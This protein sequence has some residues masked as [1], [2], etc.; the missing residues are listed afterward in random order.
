MFNNVERIG[1]KTGNFNLKIIKMIDVVYYCESTQKVLKVDIRQ[2]LETELFIIFRLEN[3]IQIIKFT[4][5]KKIYLNTC[6][7]N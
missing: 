6:Q 2:Q 5:S 7:Y 1:I 4:Y 3:K